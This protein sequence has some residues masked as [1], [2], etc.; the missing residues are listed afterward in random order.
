MVT[1]LGLHGDKAKNNKAEGVKST[2]P[3]LLLPRRKRTY[4]PV[5][6]SIIRGATLSLSKLAM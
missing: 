3:A 4:F 6:A 1:F 2:S 5:R